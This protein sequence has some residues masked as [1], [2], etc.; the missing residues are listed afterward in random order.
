MRRFPAFRL[1]AAVLLSQCCAPLSMREHI[2][3]TRSRCWTMTKPGAQIDF[4]DQSRG[5]KN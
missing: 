3:I 1:C 2:R 5:P 4:A